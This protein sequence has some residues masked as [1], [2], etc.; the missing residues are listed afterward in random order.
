MSKYQEEAKRLADQ[1]RNLSEAVRLL[2][3]DL[4]QQV[5]RIGVLTP[6]EKRS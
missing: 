6:A 5:E 4:G 1:L 2:S 3:Q